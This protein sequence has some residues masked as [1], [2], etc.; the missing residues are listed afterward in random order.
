M[1][2]MGAYLLHPC[3]QASS[4]PTRQH[5]FRNMVLVVPPAPENASAEVCI[6]TDLEVRHLIANI[7]LAAIRLHPPRRF[8]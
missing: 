8:V 6:Y 4:V 5:R 2:V 3:Y 7:L 1:T